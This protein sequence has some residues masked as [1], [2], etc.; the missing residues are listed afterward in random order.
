MPSLRLHFQLGNGDLNRRGPIPD[1]EILPGRRYEPPF[2]RQRQQVVP[3]APGLFDGAIVSD[4]EEEDE[5]VEEHEYLP[6][7][8]TGRG[9]RNDNVSVNLV[10]VDCEHEHF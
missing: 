5:E 8:S 1:M 4:G 2:R 10:P 9:N 6:T 3:P 7:K